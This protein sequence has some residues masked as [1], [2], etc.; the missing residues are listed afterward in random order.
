MGRTYIGAS[1]KRR[2]DIR[3]VSGKGTYADDIKLPGMLHAAILRSSRAHARIRSVDTV[4]AEA[5]PGVAWIFTSRHVGEAA[6]R[7]PM[8]MYRLPGLE[9]YLQPILAQGKVRYVGE[10]VAVVVAASRYVAEDALDAIEVEYEDLPEVLDVAAALR[11]DVLIHEEAGTNLAAVHEIRIGDAAGAFEKADYTRRELFRVHRHTGNP[12]ET[13]GLVATFDAGRRELTVYGMTKLLHYNRQVIAAFLGLPE[14]HVHF[15]E[16]D[17]G[18]G[19]GIRGELY[20]EDFL[21]PF[22]SMRLGRPVKWIEDRREHLMAANHSREVG[23]ELEIAARRDGALLALRARI[24]GNMG[25]YVR[26]HGGL[27]P[28]STAALLTG[29]YRIPNYECKVHCVVTNKTGMGTYRAPGRY[30]SCFFRER[31]LDMVAADLN[32]DPVELRRRNLVRPE[33]IP[34]EIGVTRPG[35]GPTVL[36]SAN[37]PSALDR[38]LNAFGYRDLQREQGR[39]DNGR[40]HGVG[41][42]CFVK[43]TGGLE[44]YEGARVALGD[45]PSVAVYLSIN[46]LGQGHETA[47]AQICAD[48]LSVPMEW[49][50]VFHGNTDLVPFGW[51]T[52]ASRGTVMCGNA[53]YLAARRLRQ[54][55]LRIAGDHL[56]IDPDRLE[57]EEGK[58]CRKGT[59]EPLLDLK[60]LLAHVR[61]GVRARPEQPALEETAY[62]NSSQLTH[63]YGVHVA[64]VAVDPET[65]LVEVLKYMV[66]EDVGRCINPMLVHGQAVGAAVQGIGA[67]LCEE[68]VYGENGQLLTTTFRDYVL[69]SSADVPPI[70]SIVLEEAPS[71]LNPLGVK[72][73]GEG[74]IVGTGAVLANAVSHAL[75]PLGVEINELPLS[76][77][78]VRSLIRRSPARHTS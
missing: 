47:M 54:K 33:E 36:D 62:F 48:G 41:L 77:D 2:E 27:V 44:P 71:P 22:A 52:F 61:A 20:P 51:G 5:V 38:A 23:C 64:R 21:I 32:L 50:S 28:C 30:E 39:L 58:I 10:P 46:V 66:V 75:S 67:T 42:A 25:A 16:N 17:V 34:Y 55:L 19:F 69:P 9:R 59:H 56:S 68:L 73:A 53:V 18:G 40:Y 26:T 60:T 7:I 72:G 6:A 15:I 1:I 70:E 78:R 29:P 63:S 76:P 35:A 12:L 57:I 11:D 4:R 31:L 45:G 43:N 49:V 37:F 3:F 74:G 24:Y 14:H 13:R 65:G 8:R